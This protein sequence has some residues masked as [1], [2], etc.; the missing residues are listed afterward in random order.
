MKNSIKKLLGKLTILAGFAA[1]LG[2]NQAQAADVTWNKNTNGTYDWSTPANWVSSIAPDDPIQDGNVLFT[3]NA[4][5]TQAYTVKLDRAVQT[6]R[7]GLNFNVNVTNPGVLTFDLNENRLVIEGGA[8]TFSVNS[9]GVNHAPLHFVNGSLELGTESYSASL[10]VGIGG[11]GNQ[12]SEGF[13]MVVGADAV[14]TI[15][16]SVNLNNIEVT[17][18]TA[19]YKQVFTLD[20]SNA[21][22]YAGEEE[23]TLKVNGSIRVGESLAPSVSNNRGKDGLLLLGKVSTIEIGEELSVG[24]NA[25]T[26]VSPTGQVGK[27]V[28]QFHAEGPEE[29]A[30]HIGK[31]LKLGVGPDSDGSIANLPTAL[32]LRVGSAATPLVDRGVIHVGYLNQN[33]SRAGNAKGTLVS[34]GGN[35]SAWLT[36]LRVGENLST[37]TNSSANGT[38]DLSESTLGTLDISGAAVIGKGRAAVGTLSLKDGAASSASLTV[39]TATSPAS[40]SV[41]SLDGTTWATDTLIVGEFG[42]I[43]L[44]LSTQ[45][46][47]GIDIL[48][49]NDAAFTING[50]GKVTVHFGD[51]SLWG[52]RMAGDHVTLMQGYVTAGSLIGAGGSV[53]KD[54]TY[55]YFAIIPE[56]STMFLL[57]LGG[58]VVMAFKRRRNS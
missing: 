34:E 4:A 21:K 50:A 20:L 33:A 8:L 26:T 10:V 55:T 22:F 35:F 28:V 1:L 56:P 27:G 5:S 17:A 36:E 6:L 57:M 31:S 38:L 16:N 43:V 32:D 39:G 7:G 41:L 23:D 25:R 40:R 14:E 19:N 52:I 47:G 9:T 54:D 37:H 45:T 42:D 58:V 53:F 11:P 2:G 48:T 13:R 15:F 24:I 29:V 49:D 18:N 30:L 3:L 51:A 46:E 44:T 12:Q